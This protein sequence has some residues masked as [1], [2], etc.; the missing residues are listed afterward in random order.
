MSDVRTDRVHRD[1]VG[2]ELECERAWEPAHRPLR[3][4]IRD[5]V[6]ITAEAGR[7]GDVHDPPASALDQMRD[8]ELAGKE[9][10]DDVDVEDL[11]E[12]LRGHV[13]CRRLDRT[14][15]TGGV[16]EDVEPSKTL[17]G[18]ADHRTDLAF[19]R[20]VTGGDE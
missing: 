12:V 9:R 19:L 16:D 8:C 10:P 14:D 20:H 5:A 13:L 3:G 17:D 4:R 2:A 15:H 6:A 1:V 7:S 18:R 11:A